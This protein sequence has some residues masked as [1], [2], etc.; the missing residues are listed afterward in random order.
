MSA[1]P[2]TITCFL[3]AVILVAM[4]IMALM[5]Q[6][7]PFIKSYRDNLSKETKSVYDKIVEERGRLYFT[8]YLLGVAVSLALIFINVKLLKQKIP[9]S[10][11]VCLTVVAST[12]ISHFYYTLSPKTSYMVSLLKTDKERADWLQVYKSMQYYYHISFALGIAAVGVF[13]YAFRGK[14]V[15]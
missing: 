10:A 4:I 15:V 2:C 9:I 3:A 1:I 6:Y 14:C 11:M 8:G 13:S 12:V 5:V 7:D